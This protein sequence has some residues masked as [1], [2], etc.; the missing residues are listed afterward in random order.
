[1]HRFPLLLGAAFLAAC[2]SGDSD[3]TDAADSA[4]TA[5]ATAE[6]GTDPDVVTQG[7]GIPAGYMGQVDAPRAGREPA[8][9]AQASY[10]VSDGR[11]EVRTGPAHIVYA[12]G[13]TASGSY[14]VSTTVEQ[15]SA[16]EHAEAFGLIVGGSGLDQLAGQRY[17]Y[18]IVRHTG[19]Y[20]VRVRDGAGT[21]DVVGWTASDA[22]PKSDADGRATYNL[23][24]R[25][26][27][28]SAHFLVNDRQVAAAAKADVPTDGIAGVR[29]NHNLHLRV[30]PPTV[31]RGS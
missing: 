19:D 23:A 2:A 13:D 28:D 12:P 31:R 18:F 4:A 7:G 9:L 14:T 29:I 26:T 21:R 22:V 24:V 10:A 17:T 25:V 11:W 3:A 1:M 6:S 15:L 27:A 5:A 20:M 30:T 8:D 16:P